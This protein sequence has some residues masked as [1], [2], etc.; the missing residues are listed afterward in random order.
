MEQSFT[1]QEP[2]RRKAEVKHPDHLGLTLGS[3]LYTYERW[4]PF[5]HHLLCP[6]I[7]SV[8]YSLTQSINEY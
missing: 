6:R 2:K 7:S 8:I 1:D 4:V 5:A 3:A